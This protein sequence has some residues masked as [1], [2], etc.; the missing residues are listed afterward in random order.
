MITLCQT[1]ITKKMSQGILD[2]RRRSSVAFSWEDSPGVSKYFMRHENFSSSSYHFKGEKILP[3]PPSAAFR[4]PI[5]E[6]SSSL[7]DDPF[8]AAL[9]ECTKR[10]NTKRPSNNSGSSKGSK[11]SNYFCIFSCKQSL[12]E[13]KVGN[14]VKLSNLPP[15]PGSRHRGRYT[16]LTSANDDWFLYRYSGTRMQ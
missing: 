5:I 9:I 10:N 8:I 3:P 7:R 2:T 4:P 6:K 14:F 12:D 15:I 1:Y 11:K 16:P 13:V